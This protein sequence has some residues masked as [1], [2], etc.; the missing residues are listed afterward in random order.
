M[1]NEEEQAK[2]E[3]RRL[4]LDELRKAMG[5]VTQDDIG[6]ILGTLTMQVEERDE[7]G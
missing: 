5:Q 3:E 6:D 7:D 4:Y 1:T 2:E